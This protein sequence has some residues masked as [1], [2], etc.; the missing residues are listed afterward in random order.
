M[1]LQNELS[2]QLYEANLFLICL[3]EHLVTQIQIYPDNTL[4][5]Q[6]RISCFK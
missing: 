6:Y 5:S 4:Q 3:N 1:C 2:T